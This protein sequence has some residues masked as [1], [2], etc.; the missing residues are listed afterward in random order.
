MIRVTEICR[1]ASQPLDK[2]VSEARLGRPPANE[3]MLQ[4]TA[5]HALILRDNRDSADIPS[6]IVLID[7]DN[8]RTKQAQ[9]LK[10]QAL[11]ENKVP[12]LAKDY[13]VARESIDFLASAL[14]QVFPAGAEYEVELQGRADYFSDIVGH[15]DCIA[16]DKIIDLKIS[17][18]GGDFN[19][20]IFDSAYQLQVYLYM[21][22][23]GKTSAE[24]VFINPESLTITRKTLDY[25]T[26]QSEAESLLKLAHQKQKLVAEATQHALIQ[27]SDYATPQWA[28]ANLMQGE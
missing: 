20:L 12:M 23:S 7:S 24:I 1:L 18:K 5:W 8:Y 22:L 27:T 26:I 13:K 28:Y 6:E 3:A 14:N 9:E 11:A 21:H 4:G 19:K 25:Y 16:G 15:T 10:A 17:T 2:I